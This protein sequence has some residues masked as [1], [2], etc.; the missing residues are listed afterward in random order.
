MFW[1][2]VDQVL[3]LRTDAV[4]L[5]ATLPGGGR[6]ALLLVV[7]AGLSDAIGESLVL[8]VNRVRLR[9]FL[10][11]LA[12]SA[13]LFAFTYLFWTSSVWLVAR[14]AF[15]ASAGYGLVARVV[16]F[17]YAPRLFGFM[18]FVPYFG[19]PLAALVQ[20]WSVLA[21]LLGVR[22][23]LD[24]QPWQALVC[25]ALGGLMLLVLERT[26][27]RPIIAAARWI[28]GRAAGV[29]LVTD[30]RGLSAL[31]DAGPDAGLAPSADE[32]PTAAARRDEGR[33]R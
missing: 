22:A 14:L 11:S 20:V 30:R 3:R 33:S 2:L 19:Q 31:I 27:G 29:D 26:V 6:L 21:V 12:L 9:R 32:G 17:A 7:L 18:A 1:P 13:I 25:V 8:F 28:R 16:G 10:I 4:E 5:L 23:A 15:D 24:L